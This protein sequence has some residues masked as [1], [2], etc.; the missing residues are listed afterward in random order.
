MKSKKKIIRQIDMIMWI[1]LVMFLT[2]RISVLIL[3]NITAEETG[4][5]IE[6]VHTTYEA[7]PIF[8]SLI[9][10][11]M[12]G[13]VLQFVVIPAIGYSVYFVYRRKALEGKFNMDSLQFFTLF[14]FFLILFNF[15]NDVA[16]LIGRL[17]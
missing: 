8:K 6:A 12:L 13:Y 9:R 17:M 11:R 16:S 14:V 7:N 3:F 1:S 2:M 10:L 4:A 5:D 15:V